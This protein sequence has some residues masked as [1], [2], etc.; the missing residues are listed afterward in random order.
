MKTC[1]GFFKKAGDKKIYHQDI[2]P[3]NIFLTKDGTI[4]IGDF[5]A[6]K[7]S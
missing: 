5:G 7:R 6:A 1:I 3:A 4:K 2:K